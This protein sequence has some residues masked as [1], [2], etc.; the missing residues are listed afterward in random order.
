MKSTATDDVTGNNKLKKRTSMGEAKPFK[1]DWIADIK[2]SHYNKLTKEY[3]SLV[4]KNGPYFYFATLT[5]MSNIGPTNRY[6]YTN[7]LLHFINQR[8]F[9][10][11]YKEKGEF[12]QGFAFCEDH[13]GKKLEGSIHIHLLIK[14]DRK[15]YKHDFLS[16]K[17][18]FHNCAR[19]VM[20]GY[21]IPVFTDSCVDIGDYF[22]DGAIQY[23]F[24]QINDGKI[25]RVKP[26]GVEGLSDNL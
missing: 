1:R 8:V 17:G 7:N 4:D 12:M 20:N 16:Y 13:L 3:M 21:D 11:K 24:K 14:G 10:R 5:F 19:M 18:I 15:Y 26:L 22:D 9:T 25:L 23:C 6:Q 2:D